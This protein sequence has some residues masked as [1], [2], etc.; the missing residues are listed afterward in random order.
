MYKPDELDWQ[1]IKTLQ[2]N[3][4]SANAAIAKQLAVTEGTVRSRTKKLIDSGILK[5]TG[6]INPEFLEDYQLVSIGIN[7]K[8]SKQLESKAREVSKLP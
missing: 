3:G 6:L 7:V 8:E 2:T 5:I 4:R 1:I